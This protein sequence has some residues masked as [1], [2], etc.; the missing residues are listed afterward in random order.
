MADFVFVG[1]GHLASALIS[2]LLSSGCESKQIKVF[3]RN[4]E[5][6]DFFKEKYSI[7]GSSNLEDLVQAGATLVLA[8]RPQDF[9][10]V[11][12]IVSNIDVDFSII[13]C[14]AGLSLEKLSM[15]SKQ[16]EK[17][18]IRAMP[19]LPAVVCAGITGLYSISSI[20]ASLKNTAERLFRA[21]GTVVWLKEESLMHSITAVSGSGPGYV[22]RLMHSFYL[23]AKSTGLSDIQAQDLVANSFLGAAKMALNSAGD[24]LELCNKVCVSGGTTEAGVNK[25]NNA[26]IDALFLDVVHA[27]QHKSQNLTKD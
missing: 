9:A 16:L 25:F 24:F 22:F 1:G 11:G 6:L 13:S 19:N 5:K 3:D 18:L 26:D 4:K 23:A 2:G 15:F 7:K 21:V 12:K 20:S 17:N 10:T 27:A 14:V 8:I